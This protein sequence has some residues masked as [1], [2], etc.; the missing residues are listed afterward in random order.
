MSETGPVAEVGVACNGP[1]EG[2]YLD[3]EV[4]DFVEILHHEPGWVFARTV[5]KPV[6]HGWMSSHLLVS[7]EGCSKVLPGDV[8]AATAMFHPGVDVLGY[9]RVDAGDRLQILHCGSHETDDADWLFARRVGD[10]GAAIAAGWLS[11]YAISSNLP[12]ISWWTDSTYAWLTEEEVQIIAK[13][14]HFP[15]GNLCPQAAA[16]GGTPRGSSS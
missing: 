9:L 4:G 3:A 7:P 13:E 8:V 11:V 16:E 14:L 15:L 1:I 2:G 12:P 5:L 6:R 10:M